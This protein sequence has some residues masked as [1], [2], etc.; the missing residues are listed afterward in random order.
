M[1]ADNLSRILATNKTP[2]PIAAFDPF[3]PG[4]QELQLIDENVEQIRTFVNTG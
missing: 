1:P 4:L 2:S 3:Q